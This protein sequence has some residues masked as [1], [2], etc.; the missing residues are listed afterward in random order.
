MNELLKPFPSRLH[1]IELR[2]QFVEQLSEED[3]L[4]FDKARENKDKEAMSCFSEKFAKFSEEKTKQWDEELNQIATENQRVF[5]DRPLECIQQIK[6]KMGRGL[7]EHEYASSYGLFEIKDLK[8]KREAGSKMAKGT[9]WEG[10]VS[11]KSFH[12]TVIVNG[13]KHKIE[14]HCYYSSRDREESAMRLAYNILKKDVG[15]ND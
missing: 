15:I 6:E 9:D 13:K 1:F 8:W 2:T 12:G 7:Y 11:S 14:G 4:K 10:K 3:K 5:K